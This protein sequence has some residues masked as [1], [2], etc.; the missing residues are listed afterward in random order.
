MASMTNLCFS[1]LRTEIDFVRIGLPH[2]HTTTL[3]EICSICTYIHDSI[4]SF[5]SYLMPKSRDNSVRSVRTMRH[6]QE[7][8]LQG[9]RNL[10]PVNAFI[11]LAFILT[12]KFNKA[13]L[14]A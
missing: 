11:L 3:A 6:A 8:R 5:I 1:V 14:G 7:F 4:S 2:Q 9:H 12:S 10:Q 13:R